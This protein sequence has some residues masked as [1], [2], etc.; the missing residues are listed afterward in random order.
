MNSWSRDRLPSRIQQFRPQSRAANVKFIPPIALVCVCAGLFV[1]G[2]VNPFTW[3]LVVVLFGFALFL[4][5]VALTRKKKRKGDE[6]VEGD[7]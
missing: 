3:M 7:W 1:F 4:V 2:G 6:Y 5:L